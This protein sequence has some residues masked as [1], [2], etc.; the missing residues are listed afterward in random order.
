MSR[1]VSRVLAALELLLAHGSISGPE[2]GR[3]LGVD[4][5]TVRRYIGSLEEM[6]IPVTAESGRGGGYSLVAGFK[7]PPMTFSGEE[8][9]SL[10]LGLLAVRHLGLA[11][12]APGIESARAKLERVLPAPL[13]QRARA[14]EATLR[15]ELPEA[16]A[17]ASGALLATVAEATQRERRLRILYLARD[18]SETERDLDSYGIAFRGGRWYVAGHCH[19]RGGPRTFRLDRI[20]QVRELP[21]SFRRPPDFDVLAHITASIAG[22]PRAHSAVILLRCDLKV[23][24]RQVFGTLGLLEERAEGTRLRVQTDDLPWLARELARFEVPFDIERPAALRRALATHLR[25]LASRLDP[26][27]SPAAP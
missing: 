25:K 21:E 14:A 13:R 16:R 8:A 7:L 22:L 20:R 5:R 3:R 17:G 10:S 15:L 19:L 4:P 26:P 23:A 2:L 24:R 9:L 27:G 11:G 1:P 6:G 18:G 12:A